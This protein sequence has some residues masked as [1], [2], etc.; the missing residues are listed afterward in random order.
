M[1]K[2]ITKIIAITLIIIGLSLMA[3]KFITQ[4]DLGYYAW[5]MPVFYCV[6]TIISYAL[7]YKG[8]SGK[9]GAFFARMSGGMMMRMF[10]CIIFVVIYLY[11]SEVTSIAIVIYFMFL[12]FIYTTFEIYDLVYKL[13]S[14][15]TTIQNAE[16]P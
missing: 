8:K 2:F 12:Y 3:D 16:K 13:R 9:Q 7:I 11:F 14:E 1:K 4:I 6:L 15:K 10:F 5:I